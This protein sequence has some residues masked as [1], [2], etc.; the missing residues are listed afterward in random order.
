MAENMRILK[1]AVAA[2]FLQPFNILPGFG[3]HDYTV[4]AVNRAVTLPNCC[5]EGLGFP[6]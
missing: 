3:S 4:V 5:A 1:M 2:A 6:K